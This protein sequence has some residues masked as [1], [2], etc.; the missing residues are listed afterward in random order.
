M[1]RIYLSGPMTGIEDFNFPAFHAKA[2]QL[3]EAGFDVVNP[4][5]IQTDTTASWEDC[6]RQDIA[7]L[8]TCTGIHLLPG[9]QHS[10]GAKLE[11]HIATALNMTVTCD[12]QHIGWK[13]RR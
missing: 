1:T 13:T 3:R 10:R 9:W 11:L 6:L 4:A 5:E 7:E 8:V 12:V 2:A